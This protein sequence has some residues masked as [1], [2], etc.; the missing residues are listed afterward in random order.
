MVGMVRSPQTPHAANNPYYASPVIL[1][2]F[3]RPCWYG[4]P[5]APDETSGPYG[6]GRKATLFHIFSIETA[7]GLMVSEP[8][9]H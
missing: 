4:M 2:I 8:S 7:S 1:S 5:E 9:T 6:P 3:R